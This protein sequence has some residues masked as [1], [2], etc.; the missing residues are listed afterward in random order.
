MLLT[1][2]TLLRSITYQEVYAL[3][4]EMGALLGCVTKACFNLLFMWL[5]SG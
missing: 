2:Q 5:L 1:T 3:K 4:L